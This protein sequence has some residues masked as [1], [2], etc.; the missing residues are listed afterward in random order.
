[1]E[2]EMWTWLYMTIWTKLEGN[3]THHPNSRDQQ[4]TSLTLM[5]CLTS[6]LSSRYVGQ[7]WGESE[8]CPAS[9]GDMMVTSLRPV[10]VTLSMEGHHLPRALTSFSLSIWNSLVAHTMAFDPQPLPAAEFTAVQKNMFSG[11]RL[12][13]SRGWLDCTVHQ[14]FMFWSWSASAGLFSVPYLWASRATRPGHPWSFS[15]CPRVSDTITG[16]FRS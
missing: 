6:F 10:P 2:H 8:A 1:M 4:L 14:L 5:Q 15:I 11:G 16:R 9:D 3:S 13:A 7:R 12:V